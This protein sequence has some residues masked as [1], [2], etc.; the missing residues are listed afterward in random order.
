[1]LKNYILR[2][3]TYTHNSFHLKWYEADIP[4]EKYVGS[5]LMLPY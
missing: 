2:I 1:M 5:M 3:L 4:L